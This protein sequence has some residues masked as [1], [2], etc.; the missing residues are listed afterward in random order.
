MNSNYSLADDECNWHDKISCQF[1]QLRNTVKKFDG[2]SY[3]KAHAP[4]ESNE[5]TADWMRQF[6]IALEKEIRSSETIDLR[7]ATFPGSD[8]PSYEN[9]TLEKL[10]HYIF[11]DC[12]F[13]P[14]LIITANSPA[15]K[16]GSFKAAK[17]DENCVIAGAWKQIDCHNAVFSGMIT[18]NAVSS[19]ASFINAKFKD[20]SIFGGNASRIGILDLSLAEF[21]V[22]PVFQ[23]NIPQQT[24]FS[25]ARF[26]STARSGDSEGAYRDLRI[27]FSENRA[28]ELEGLCYAYERRCQRRSLSWK[29]PSEWFAKLI[30]FMYDFSSMYGQSYGRAFALFIVVQAIFGISYAWAG[31]Y[32]ASTPLNW[33]L[34]ANISSFTLAQVAK[35]FALLT[36]SGSQSYA[37]LSH[38]NCM[39]CWRLA[40]FAQSLLSLTILALFIL[41]LR[42]RFRRE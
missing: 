31:G 21:S 19:R 1:H 27:K 20:R 23:D 10:D 13:G 29:R 39:S 25:R 32:I 22:V 17:F 11:D 40:T 5:K 37:V 15:T 42:W 14:R 2:R 33:R 28:R 24:I 3:C 26:R 12:Q 35:P 34:V 18:I 16:V 8:S 38:V 36:D 4:I 7:G 30:S 9:L 41:A 6:V